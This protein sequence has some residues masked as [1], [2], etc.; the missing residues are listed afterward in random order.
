MTLKWSKRGKE[1]RGRNTLK[2]QMYKRCGTDI[3]MEIKGQ[4]RGRRDTRGRGGDT[5]SDRGRQ[6]NHQGVQV[7]L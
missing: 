2:E 3:T 4:D 5:I 7:K 6:T 1:K